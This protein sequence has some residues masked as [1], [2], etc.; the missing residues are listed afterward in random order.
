M[1]NVERLQVLCDY[2]LVWINEHGNLHVIL[3]YY[4]AP[5]MDNSKGTHADGWEIEVN[6]SVDNGVTLHGCSLSL[7]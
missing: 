5:A 3:I 6:V 1:P 2:S 7:K 4:S